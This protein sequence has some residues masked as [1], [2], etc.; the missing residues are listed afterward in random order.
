MSGVCGWCADICVVCMYK[1]ECVY[2]CMYSVYVHACGV[3]VCACMYN[4]YVCAGG[5]CGVCGL[6]PG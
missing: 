5:A 3:Y 4:V 6:S 2:A 1:C